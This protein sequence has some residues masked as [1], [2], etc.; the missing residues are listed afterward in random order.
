M[1][2][3][4]DLALPAY[5]ASISASQ[6]L[7]SEITQPDHIP[8]SLDSCF[9]VGSSTNP[10]L[11]ENPTLQRQ[12]DDIKSPSRSVAL[13]PLLGQLRLA[14]LSSATQPNSGAWM[15]CLPSTAIGT[16]LDNESFQIAI[17]Q[18]LGLPVCAPHKCRCGAMVDRCGLHPLSFRFSAGRLPR[19][20]ALND[21][22]KCALTSAGFNAV[23]EPVGL[24]RGDGKRPE[25]MTVFPFSR[26]KCL[27]WDCT[28]VDYVSLSA[29][30]LT[31]TE[32]G[33]ASR[34]AEVR[35]NLKYEG[36][37]DRY[38]FQAIAIETSCVFGR[39]TNAFISR[40]GHLT[41]SISGERREA[42]FLRQRL[43]LATVRGNAQS[44]TQA[45]RPSS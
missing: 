2:R 22:I 28:C 38:I 3:A 21:I 35:K 6:S 39:D 15:N 18:R 31:A 16:L 4:S 41:T 9:D 25:G 8:L 37:C 26:G 32:P 12:W 36:L 5:L 1:R 10:S 14:C 24:N 34:S 27:I 23:L 45:G 44:V 13:R 33:S 11:S 40:L 42:E 29:L 20:S 17:S 19:H 43:S 30:A 7:I